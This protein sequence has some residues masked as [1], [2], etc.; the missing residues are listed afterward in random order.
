MKNGLHSIVL[1]FFII[2]LVACES[3]KSPVEPPIDN[4]NLVSKQSH[5]V[6]SRWMSLQVELSENSAGMTP[7]VVARNFAYTGLA[8]YEALVGGMP[9]YVSLAGKIPDFQGVTPVENIE[10]YDWNLVLNATL[11]NLMQR[12]YL[13]QN[14][15]V[16]GRTLGLE[17]ELYAKYSEGVEEE[18]ANRSVAYG[19]LIASEIYEFS[20]TDG[21]EMAFINNFPNFTIPKGDGKWVPTPHQYIPALQPFWGSVRT[22][23]PNNAQLTQPPPPPAFS[24]DPNSTFMK[25]TLYMYDACI[26]KDKDQS[27]IAHFWD[28]RPGFSPTPPGHSFSILRQALEIDNTNL[29]KAVEAYARL[30]MAQHDAFVSCWLTKYE[31]NL[32]RPVTVLRETTDPEFLPD[33]ITPPFPEYTSGHSVQSGAMSAVLTSMFGD[34]FE[35]TDRTHEWRV[36]ELQLWWGEPRKFKSFKQ[37]A[38]EAAISRIYGG[39]HYMFACVEGVTQ[40]ERVG[41]N[42]M[43]I[44]FKK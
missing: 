25:S 26:N 12:F 2:L 3:D 14:L 38:D 4:R 28:D 23:F 16:N 9:E 43:S 8:A 32:I 31:Y 37:A 13:R 24:T 18:I 35:F 5:E 21:Q 33:I 10:D 39:I 11:S 22:F 20:K 40:G 6:A 30:G 1:L 34:N 42:I 19:R 41:Q 7:P 17:N 15:R 36:S 29:A 44:N 27:H